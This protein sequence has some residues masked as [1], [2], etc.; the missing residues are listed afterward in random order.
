MEGKGVGLVL[1]WRCCDAMEAGCVE[2]A[3]GGWL[4]RAISSVAMG[5]LSVGGEID[6]SGRSVQVGGGAAGICSSWEKNSR[7]VE[8]WALGL[9]DVG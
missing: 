6:A 9:G 5:S 3:G 7:G 1:S 8:K 2:V 4:L